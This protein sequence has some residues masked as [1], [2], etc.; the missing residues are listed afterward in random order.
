[1]Q[2]KRRETGVGIAELDPDILPII[3]KHGIAPSMGYG[4][5]ETYWGK[6]MKP[7]NGTTEKTAELIGARPDPLEDA[8]ATQIQTTAK[9]SKISA[10]QLIASLRG[11]HGMGETPAYPEDVKGDMPD[12]PNGY[13]DG[14][15]KHPTSS[16]WQMAGFS[17]WWPEPPADHEVDQITRFT[18][19]EDI[20][21]GRAMWA[22]MNGQHAHSTRTELAALLVAMLRP[23]PLHIAT[24]SQALIDKAT[25]IMDAA[26]LWQLRMSTG[27]D[28]WPMSNPYGK[29]WSSQVDGDLWERFWAASLLR[30]P[31][32]LRLNKA[33][34]HTSIRDIFN[35]VITEKDRFGNDLSDRAATSGTGEGRPGLQQ[36]ANWLAQ[37]H[38]AYCKF[39]ERIHLYIVAMAKGGKEDQGSHH[40]GAP[41]RN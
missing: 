25:K 40:Q 13:T 7:G 16:L 24:D 5:Y 34:A 29:P 17:M 27:S 22:C 1:M 35:G 41:T 23:I 10:R 19:Q 37:K 31:R 21:G 4:D 14:G 8:D 11:A 2:A 12:D 30:R 26:V 33:K 9:N 32:M 20:A 39:M 36:F 3:I 6:E 28:H 18:F 15:V 38:K